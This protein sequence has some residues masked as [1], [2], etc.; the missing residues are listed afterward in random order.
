VVVAG[1]ADLEQHRFEHRTRALM[2]SG[3]QQRLAERLLL[4]TGSVTHVIDQLEKQDLVKRVA[5]PR[6]RRVLYADLTEKGR[7]LI[8]D[9]FPAHAASIRQA[10]A[11]LSPE[12]QEAATTL[13]KKLGLAAMANLE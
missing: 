9:I 7:A 1:I 2:L 11:G 8:A 5:C 12:E 4:A 13:L 10:V 6:D 3:G